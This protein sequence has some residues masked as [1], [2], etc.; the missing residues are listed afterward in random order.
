MANGSQPAWVSGAL[1]FFALTATVAFGFWVHLYTQDAALSE[2]RLYMD[3]ILLP[4]LRE[5]RG[6]LEDSIEPLENDLD[7]RIT[8]LTTLNNLNTDMRNSNKNLLDSESVELNSIESHTDKID[9]DFKAAYAESREAREEHNAQ[10]K[11]VQTMTAELEERLVALRQLIKEESQSLEEFQKET[12]AKHLALDRSNAKLEERVQELL[13]QQE[14]SRAKLLADGKV[15]AARATEGFII[16]N[17]GRKDGLR[18]GTVFKVFA[19]SGG[20]NIVKGTVEVTRVGDKQ[21]EG[22]V[23]EEMS[24]NEPIIPGDF[25]HN[26]VFNPAETKVFVISGV[27]SSFTQEELGRFITEAGG[28]VDDGLSTKTH[29]LVAGRNSQQALKEASRFGITILSEDQL[30]DFIRPKELSR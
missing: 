3:N 14:I 23:I 8:R 16:M 18:I 19:R 25:L 6:L 4:E 26:P 15:M 5:R 20:R 29:Y 11:H 24:V 9:R 30:I 27:F 28:I 2:Q 17:L 1:V 13:D 22:H 12:R 10:E 7:V 21:S